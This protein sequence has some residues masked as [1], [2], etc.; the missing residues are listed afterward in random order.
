MKD[1]PTSF[2]VEDCQKKHN[3][4]GLFAIANVQTEE[5]LERRSQREWA[6]AGGQTLTAPTAL[7]GRRLSAVQAAAD[8][9]GICMCMQMSPLTLLSY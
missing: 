9:R 2:Q 5:L 1:A 4:E 7:R 6:E 8:K 3:A